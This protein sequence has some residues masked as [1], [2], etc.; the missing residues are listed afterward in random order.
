MSSGFVIVT[1]FKDSM[2]DGVVVRDIDSAF[3]S[4]DPGFML[5][6]REAGVE[7][8]GDGTVH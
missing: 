2:T 6:V 3:V 5:P 8:K 7:G 4:K 1:P